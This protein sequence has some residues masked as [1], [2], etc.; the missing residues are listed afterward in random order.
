[1]ARAALGWTTAQLAEKADVG[2]N[3]INRFE[4]GDD[5][6]VSSVD[7]MRAALETE[8]VSLL[9]DG[10]V[11]G[12]G[13]GVRMSGPAGEPKQGPLDAPM[14]RAGRKMKAAHAKRVKD[15]E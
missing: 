11:K 7:K 9:A 1:M 12:G 3:T 15:A 13:V 5:A 8:G 14:V 10:E 4:R 6:R 2:V